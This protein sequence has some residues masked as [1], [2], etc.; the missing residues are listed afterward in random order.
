MEELPRVERDLGGGGDAKRDA[1]AA[2]LEGGQRCAE[3]A[4]AHRLDDEVVLGRRGDLLAHHDV[5]GAQLAE[6]R[7]LV[8]AP[9]GRRHVS[10][11]EPR[12][13]HREVADAAGGARDEHASTEERPSL[14]EGVQRGES[15]HRKSGR[16]GERHL[17]GQR[18]ERVCRHRHPLRPRAFR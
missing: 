15:G 9:G 7:L 6:S 13:L 17:V 11:G 5:V 12:E 2:A 14:G 1:D 4:S 10:A 16:L 18:G 8:G 3:R